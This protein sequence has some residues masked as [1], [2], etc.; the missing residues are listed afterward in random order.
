MENKNKILLNLKS[1]LDNKLILI[2]HKML[3]IKITFVGEVLR[4]ITVVKLCKEW[5]PL[6]AHIKPIQQ[7][8]EE[9]KIYQWII[10]IHINQLHMYQ[11]KRDKTAR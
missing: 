10:Y 1:L 5:Q 8:L 6:K 7:N 4:E 9:R 3:K 11:N 2:R